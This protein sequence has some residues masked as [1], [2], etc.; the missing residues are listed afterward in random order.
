MQIAKI[1]N[2]QIITHNIAESFPVFAQKLIFHILPEQHGTLYCEIY[3]T[4]LLTYF[5]LPV[6]LYRYFGGKVPSGSEPLCSG[7][8]W[9][10]RRP[11]NPKLAAT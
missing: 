5:V 7:D 10:T 3:P 11:S 4:Y 1:Q 2:P 9:R 6:G 8:A